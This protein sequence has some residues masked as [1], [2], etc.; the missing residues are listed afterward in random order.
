MNGY[1]HDHDLPGRAM[2]NRHARKGNGEATTSISALVPVL[3]KGLPALL[4]DVCRALR[5]IEGEYADFL[6]E[7]RLLVTAAAHVAI[8]ELVEAA[9]QRLTGPPGRFEEEG[10]DPSVAEPED[11]DGDALALF[12]DAGRDHFQRNR[13]LLPLLLAYQAGGRVAWRHIAAS[14]VALQM[15]ADALAALAEGVFRAVDRISAVTTDGYLLEQAES[16]G[17]REHLLSALAEQLLAEGSNPAT[18]QELAQ[19]AGWALPAEV[20]LVVVRHDDPAG[21]SALARLTPPCL[22]VRFGALPG[23]IVPDPGAPGARHRLSTLLRGCSAVVGPT[24]PLRDLPES[25]R[26]T[27]DA[28]W[29]W[30]TSWAG[31]RPFFVDEHLDAIIVHRDE[32]LLDTLRARCLAPL[33]GAARGSRADFEATLRSWLVHMGDRRAVAAELQVHPQTVRYRLNR[34]HELFGPVLTDPA[35]RLRL[36]LAL[37]WD[38]PAGA[39]RT[40]REPGRRVGNEPGCPTPPGPVDGVP[41][42]RAPGGVPRKSASPAPGT[43]RTD[44][45]GAMATSPTGPRRP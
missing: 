10:S 42:P 6:A 3:W 35:G 43:R 36:L 9:E 18:V 17:V 31:Q 27:L 13:P 4:D 28:T 1:S 21:P 11:E 22:H 7:Q 23:L 41:R 30:E 39:L 20:A 2:E 12:K 5:S 16:A 45:G 19:Q 25:V 15:P 37:A 24:V 29:V 40:D 14:A 33:Q 32:R 26:V 8:R 44:G 34:L 38:C